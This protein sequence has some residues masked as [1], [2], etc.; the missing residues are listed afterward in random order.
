MIALGFEAIRSWQL[1]N[2][3]VVLCVLLYKVLN[4]HR[5]VRSTGDSALRRP[6]N[7]IPVAQSAAETAFSECLVLPQIATRP[8][9]GPDSRKGVPKSGFAHRLQSKAMMGLVVP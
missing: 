3:A 1:V 7:A 4:Q 6:R 9:S 5:A 2:V 8:E